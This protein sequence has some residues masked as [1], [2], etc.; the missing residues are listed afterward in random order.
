[1][2]SEAVCCRIHDADQYVDRDISRVS[3]DVNLPRSSHEAPVSLLLERVLEV[4]AI[5]MLLLLVLLLL[6]AGMKVLLL[7]VAMHKVR[8]LRAL[9]FRGRSVCAI[10][11]GVHRHG[12]DGGRRIVCYCSLK[13][14]RVDGRWSGNEHA[15]YRIVRE[16][17]IFRIHPHNPIFSAIVL[18]ADWLTSS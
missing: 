14:M 6:L 8:G 1:M 5:L 13:W 4:A 18:C 9:H 7:T 3:L 12:P 15:A 11:C 10:V 2:P 16:L 17:H